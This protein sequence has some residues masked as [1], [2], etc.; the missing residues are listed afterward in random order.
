[1]DMILGIY[2]DY[3]ICSTSYTTATGLSKLTDNIISHDKVTRFLSSKDFTSSDLWLEG[4]PLYKTIEDENGVL[5][6]DDSIEEKPYTDENEVIAWHWDHKDNKPTKGIN[7]VSLL[8]ESAKGSVPLGFEPVRKD[9]KVTSKK[10]GKLKRKAS[11]SKQQ[12]YRNLIKSAIANNVKFKHILNDTWFTSVENIIFVKIDCEKDLIAAVKSNR[13]VALSATDKALGKFVRIDSLELGEGKTVWLE[14][15][16]FPLRLIRQ[17]FK[18]ED[19][20]T[21]IL[22]LVSTDLELTDEQIKTIYK[23]RWKVETYHKSIK[24]NASL[25]KSPTK[26]PRT[27]INHLFASLCAYI[28]LESMTK[29]TGNNHFALK[30]KIYIESLKAAMRELQKLTAETILQTEKS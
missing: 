11:V 18:N 2:V 29:I 3:L 25:A 6:I 10:T 7:F 27:Q 16:D 28:R 19:D 13:K 22:Y 12:H 9:L 21:G 30:A 14:G 23:R 5:I 8:Y 20:S 17:V 15:I 4:K 26:T 24:Y 1:M